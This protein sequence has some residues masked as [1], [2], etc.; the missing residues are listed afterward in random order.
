MATQTAEEYFENEDNHGGYQYVT[1]SK[2][3]NRMLL[4]TTDNDSWIKN[5]R[6][7]MLVE[8]AKEGLQTLNR[9]VKKTV[10]GMEVTVGPGLFSILPQDYIDW[11]GVFVVG[12]DFKLQALKVNNSIN[13]AIGYLQDNNA[14]ILFDDQ[15]AILLSDSSNNYAHTHAPYTVSD[16]YNSCRGGLRTLD[17]TLLSKHGEVKFDP[18]RGKMLFSSDLEDKEIV[19]LYISDGLQED[20]L[21]NNEITFHKDLYLVLKA[22]VYAEAILTRKTPYAVEKD[23]ALKRYKTLLHQLKID[24][25]DFDINKMTILSNKKAL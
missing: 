10:L 18:R 9:E 3:I 21:N 7:R 11:V 5:V 15:G 16:L 22:Y 13:T 23:R 4:E 1:L 17:T 19:L 14:D 20:E 6:R 25:A 24:A 8:L 2:F 12:E